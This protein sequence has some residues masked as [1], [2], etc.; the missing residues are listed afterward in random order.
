MLSTL[1]DEKMHCIIV[2]Q[3]AISYNNICSIAMYDIGLLLLTHQLE[4]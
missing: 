4:V 2:S 1:R 3:V